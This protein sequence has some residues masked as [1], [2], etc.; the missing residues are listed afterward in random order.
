MEE[1]TQWKSLLQTMEEIAERMGKMELHN[2]LFFPALSGITAQKHSG[3]VGEV[4][5]RGQIR[6]VGEWQATRLRM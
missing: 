6:L 3:G 5:G 2:L 1:F 4:G